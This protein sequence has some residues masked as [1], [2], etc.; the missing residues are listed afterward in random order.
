MCVN[1]LSFVSFR[2]TGSKVFRLNHICYFHRLAVI[3]ILENVNNMTKKIKV[4]VFH[5]IKLDPIGILVH[6]AIEV[7]VF[8]YKSL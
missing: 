5:F 6:L 2:L 4:S 8:I 1:F 3:K 7:N